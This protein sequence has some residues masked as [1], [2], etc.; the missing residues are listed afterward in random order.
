MTAGVLTSVAL[1]FGLNVAFF[2][3][4]LHVGRA[5]GMAMTPARADRR[6]H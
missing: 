1:W 6:P 5:V 2:A 3:W 4:R